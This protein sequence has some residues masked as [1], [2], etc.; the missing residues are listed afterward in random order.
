VNDGMLWFDKNGTI[1]ERVIRAVNYYK[2]RYAQTPN[3]CFVHPNT[4]GISNL[5]KVA[6]CEM[7]TTRSVLP[8]HFWIGKHENN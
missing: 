4:K 5:K 1:E 7:R 6:G 8:N 2:G 3:I